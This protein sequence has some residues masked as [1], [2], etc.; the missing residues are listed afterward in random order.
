MG[1]E[2]EVSVVLDIIRRDC[3]IYKDYLSRDA[4][5]SAIRM[6]QAV[7]DICKELKKEIVWSIKEELPVQYPHVSVWWYSVLIGIQKDVEVFKEF[8]VYV[9]KH[10]ESFTPNIRYF[11]FYQLKALKFRFSELDRPDICVELWK[12]YEE[13]VAEFSREVHV[14]LKQIPENERNNNTVIV[15][16]E[17]LIA[18]TH[19]PTKT[20]LDRCKV[21]ITQLHKKVILIN[22]AEVL[23]Q[24]GSIPFYN[25]IFGSYNRETLNESEQIWKGIRI[26]YVQCENNMPDIKMLDLLLEQIRKIAPEYVISI[27]GNS[28]L[29]NLVNRM[30]PVLSVSLAFS[31][32]E[33]TTT[34]YQ[35]IGRRL[36]DTDKEMLREMGIAKEHVI[37]GVFTFSFRP[38]IGHITRQELGV[39]EKDFLM[40]VVGM[41]L[42]KEVTPEFL[43][44][45][46]DIIEDGMHIGFLGD[47]YEFEAKM[48]QY[49]RVKAHAS[50][51]GFAQDVLS[52]F[53]VCD[54]YL[55]PKRR[56]GGGSCL[57]AMSKGVPTV[58][59]NYGD[60][61]VSV[62]EEFCVDTYE[63]MQKKILEYYTDSNYYHEMSVK[64]V[65][66][67]ELMLDSEREFV[68]V[69]EEMKRREGMSGSK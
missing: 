60:T 67:A 42:D 16:T 4:I 18:T 32:L 59:L 39:P 7:E 22:T 3:E 21:L 41:R 47:F 33:L 10:R 14:P 44:M 5:E 1:F 6:A 20:A 61:A 69:I 36:N 64:A 53:E 46:E 15:I 58:T 24:T 34:K 54:L 51:L 11:L 68:R 23:S 9:R 65:K 8:I 29:S 63:D 31:E 30:I 35:S 40:V 38:Q 13:I 37:E 28:M 17:Q 49:P 43:Q 56:G 27:G 19:G 12:L 25:Y 62:G 50:N 55:N 2:Y 52:R 48:E 57:E 26:P 66:R 45:L